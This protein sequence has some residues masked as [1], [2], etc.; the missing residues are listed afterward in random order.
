MSQTWNLTVQAWKEVE[1]DADTKEEAI[2]KAYE[3]TDSL[4]WDGCEILDGMVTNLDTGE[5]FYVKES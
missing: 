3:E 5:V 4:E 2:K 1:V